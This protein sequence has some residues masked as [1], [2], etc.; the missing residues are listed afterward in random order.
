MVTKDATAEK[1][2]KEGHQFQ[3]Q[4]QSMKMKIE[5]AEDKKIEQVAEQALEEVSPSVKLMAAKAA[6][7]VVRAAQE[8][9][10]EK[11][12]VTET[13][14]DEIEVIK[15][16]VAIDEDIIPDINQDVRKRPQQN[17]P[18]SFTDELKNL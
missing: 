7:Q 17:I 14:T 10:E 3:T 15:R 13:I 5:A 11:E 6:E 12:V 18:P 2:V 4:T 1:A 8:V 16:P 9:T